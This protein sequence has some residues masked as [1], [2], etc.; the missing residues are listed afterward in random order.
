MAST[1]ADGH[2]VSLEGGA[3]S[4]AGDKLGKER[5]SLNKAWKVFAR[6]SCYTDDGIR[7]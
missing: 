3:P 4:A 1:P 7:V 5:R 6:R 2:A